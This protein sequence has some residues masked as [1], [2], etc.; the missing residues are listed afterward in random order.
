MRAKNNERYHRRK[1]EISARRRE[2]RARVPEINAWHSIKGGARKRGIPLMITRDEFIR[3]YFQ[4]KRICEYCG[5]PDM[6][7]D[8]NY[9]GRPFVFS[10]DRKDSRLPYSLENICQA[11]YL[12]NS[13]KSNYFSY[14]EW[15]E[16]A[17]KYVRPKWVKR[18]EALHVA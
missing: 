1:V 11:C 7:F 10:V 4:Q 3:W 13:L 14:S 8:F 5:V 16:I 2:L 15:K 17:E 9:Y 12:C 6:T 18:L